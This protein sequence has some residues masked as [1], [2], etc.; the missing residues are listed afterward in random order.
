MIACSKTTTWTS[1]TFLHLRIGSAGSR[2][3]V[4]VLTLALFGCAFYRPQSAPNLN[5]LAQ[6]RTQSDGRVRVSAAV[7]SAEESSKVFGVPL[8]DPGV[9]PVWFSIENQD[10][11]PYAF[12]S[13][14]VDPN[15]F[16]PLEAAYRNHHRLSPLANYRMNAFFLQNVIVPIIP[17]GKTISGFVYTNEELGAKYAQVQL[18]G[19]K[20]TKPKLFSFVLPVPGLRT[21]YNE[22]LMSGHFR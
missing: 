1:A 12:L 9:Q 7:L 21:H 14:S 15:R 2:C 4:V 8:Y 19:P 3:I 18:V 5:S 10:H 17:P 16:S 22:L 20:G 6:A 13:V 11:V